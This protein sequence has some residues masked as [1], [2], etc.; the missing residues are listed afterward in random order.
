MYK[1]TQCYYDITGPGEDSNWNTA[2]D[3][4]L[5]DGVKYTA[6]SLG[7]YYSFEEGFILDSRDK[8]TKGETYYILNMQQEQRFITLS[9]E[10]NRYPLSIGTT[11][12]VSQRKFRVEWDGT[13]W[14]E[15]GNIQGIITAEELYCDYGYIGGWEIDSRSLSGGKT[16]LDSID[17]IYTNNIGIIEQISANSQTGILGEIGLVY[18]STGLETTYNIGIMSKNQSIILDTMSASGATANIA[19]RSRGGTWAQCS[20]FYVMGSGSWMSNAG[21]IKL[22][23]DNFELTAPASNQK[24]I[25]ARF[26]E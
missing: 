23:S 22:C 1:Y 19:F 26:A 20:N 25:Y 2:S 24:G 8:Y 13:V 21:T 9:A 14:I 15:N 6:S 12:A 4:N 5:T 18:G 7:S 10:E 17:G 16:V 11:N 3:P